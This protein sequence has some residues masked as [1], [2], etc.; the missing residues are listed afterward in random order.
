VL[1]N[2]TDIALTTP[3]DFA[4]PGDVLVALV[5]R[6]AGV[7]PVG[8]PASIDQTAS[9]SRSWVGMYSAGNPADP[10]PLP[11]DSLWGTIDSFG[12]AGNWMIRAT[13][14]VTPAELITLTVE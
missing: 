8:W 10:P 12:F 3:L 6:T 4:G 1:D 11:A 7:N 5:N 9:Q 13:G 2:W 14:S